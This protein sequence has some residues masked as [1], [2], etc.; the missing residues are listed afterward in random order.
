L[1]RSEKETFDADKSRAAD[2]TERLAAAQRRPAEAHAVGA[3]G[4]PPAPE[5]VD[6]AGGETPLSPKQ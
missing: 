3:Q 4:W 6:A 1:G 2:F 5:F